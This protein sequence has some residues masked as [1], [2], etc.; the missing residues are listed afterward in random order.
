MGC[1]TQWLLRWKAQLP[2]RENNFQDI[3]NVTKFGLLTIPVK[4]SVESQ[5]FDI[6]SQEKT[7]HQGGH[8][9]GT[10]IA[11]VSTIFCRVNRSL[12][13]AVWSTVWLGEC[14]LPN[15]CR[16]LAIPRSQEAPMSEVE[17]NYKKLI[18]KPQHG[19]RFTT[20]LPDFYASSG[21]ATC[22]HLGSRMSQ[23]GGGTRASHQC[24]PG[25]FPGP[26]VICG[27]SLL[28]VLFSRVLWFFPSPQKPTFPI[29]TWNARAFLNEFLWTPWR[30]VGKKLHIIIF[31]LKQAGRCSPFSQ[32][33]TLAESCSTWFSFFYMH[34]SVFLTGGKRYV[35]VKLFPLLFMN[36]SNPGILY[37]VPFLSFSRN[38]FP[39]KSH[40]WFSDEV[41]NR[42]IRLVLY[43]MPL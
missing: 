35:T 33:V 4:T 12:K 1:G 21:Q 3:N 42:S 16:S 7:W 43:S 22:F 19:C 15:Q 26:G 27:L 30:S 10:S 29:R 32:E 40:A 20:D 37:I 18:S 36:L 11:T 41:L 28:L 31:S 13:E 5:K 14:L 24:V 23:S 2:F 6:W 25:S 34:S 17:R 9:H 39:K 8:L 38:N